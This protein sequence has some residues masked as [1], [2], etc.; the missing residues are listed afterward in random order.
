MMAKKRI[1]VRATTADD[2]Q[3]VRALRLEMLADTPIAFGET[4][5]A[6]Q[7][8]TEAG[9]RERGRRGA[10][11]HS[12][13]LVAIDLDTGAWAGIMGGYVDDAVGSKPLLV[14]VY[15][16]PAY[17]GKNSHVTD[18]LL[19]GVEEWARGEGD[20]L[21]L[22]VHESN[23]RAIAAYERRGFHA[24]GVTVPYVLDPS[25]RELEMRKRLR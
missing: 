6:A 17:R 21:L 10:N 8:V 7:R 4:L 1:E 15:V 16:S 12:T 11:P 19:A 13:A 9:W 2:W 3:Q 5:E 22:H 20:E 25:T 24:T 23:P 18:L 14:G